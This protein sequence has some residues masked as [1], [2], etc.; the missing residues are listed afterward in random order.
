MYLEPRGY[1]RTVSAAYAQG[2]AT[3]AQ[4][5]STISADMVADSACGTSH[6]VISLRWI[7]TIIHQIHGF[8]CG[9]GG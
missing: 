4:S 5:L 3:A 9:G 7:M 6:P 8:V 2:S 1:D